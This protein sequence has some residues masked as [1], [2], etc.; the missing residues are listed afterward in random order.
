MAC[1]NPECPCGSGCPYSAGSK[2]SQIAARVASRY[3]EAQQPELP[4]FWVTREEIA[5]VCPPCAERMSALRI[6]R[7]LASAIFGQDM[8]LLAAEQTAD[9]WKGMPKGWTNESR[10]KFWDSVGG[11]VDKCIDKMEGK[12]DDPGA[13]CS[14]LKDR[15]EKSTHWRG[16]E[17]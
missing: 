13:F 9:K 14:S 11:S 16:K 4:D 10:K 2:P 5:K 1:N 15:V 3:L 8:L 17:D 7:V 6:R 12:V